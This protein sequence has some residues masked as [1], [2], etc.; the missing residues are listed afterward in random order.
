MSGA[1]TVER[2]TVKR[3]LIAGVAALVGLAALTPPAV[4]DDSVAPVGAHALAS[5]QPRN[6]G[7]RLQD[8]RTWS[9]QTDP[10]ARYLRA[11]VPLQPRIPHDPS[12]QAHP[13]L[14]AKAQVMLMQGDYGNSFF[15]NFRANDGFAHNV[16]NFWQYADYWSPWHGSATARTPQSLYDPATS[17]W[18]TR[19]FEFG[20][21]DIPN[22]AYTNAAHRNG[23]KSIATIYFDPAFRPGLTF[24]EAFDKDPTSRGY[25]IAE[26]LVEMAK[27]FGYDGYFLNEEEGNLQDSRFRPFMSYLTSKGLYTQWYTNT[28]GTW[29]SSKASLLD[30]GR[31]MN[32]VFLNYNWPGTQDRSVEAAKAEGYDPYQSLF[33]G[34]EANQA[35]FNGKHRSA[36]ELPSLYES[37]RNHSP[38]ASVALFTP[39]DMYQ[40]GLADA[41]KPK[42]ADKDVPLFQQDPYQWMVAERERMY[43]SGVTSNPK[44]TGAHPGHSRPEV[45]V[46]DSSSWVGAADFI[47]ARSVIGGRQFH[48]DFNTGHGMRWYSAGDVSAA[49]SWTD[50]DAQSILP[51]W[52]WWIDTEGTRPS[53]DFDYGPSDRRKDVHGA[54]V[55]LLYHQVG[56]WCGGSSLV[57]HGMMSKTTTL[58][59]FKTR[60]AM[61]A[62]TSM[63][64]TFRKSSKDH[65]TMKAALVFADDPGRVVTVD[66]PGSGVKGGWH[67]STLRLGR[68]AGRTLTTLGLQFAP[69]PDY[70]MNVGAI[71]VRDGS[72]VPAAPSEVQLDTVY[73]DGQAIL[74]W[75]AAPFDDVAG[76]VVESMGPDGKIVHLASGYTDLAY[77]KAVPKKTG[78]VTFRVRAVGHDGQM[79]APST[80]SYDYSAQPRHIKVAEAATASKLLTDAVRPGVLDVTWDAKGVRVSTCRVDVH[81]VDIAKDDIDN[82]PYG[83]DVPCAAG[84]ARVPVP[85]REGHPYDLTVTA[86]HGLGLSYRGHTHDSWAAPVTLD[87]IVVE[88]KRSG[89]HMRNLT[90]PDW[91]GLQI[92]WKG[93]DGTSRK[94]TTIR[95]GGSVRG[96]WG[97]A[98]T[99]DCPTAF[100]SFPSSQGTLVMKVTDYAGNTTTQHFA[101]K[102]NDLVRPATA[103]RFT[104]VEPARQRVTVSH[105]IIPVRISVSGDQPVSWRLRGALPA[106]LR[107]TNDMSVNGLTSLAATLSGSPRSAGNHRIVVEVSDLFGNTVTRS[108]VVEAARGSA[109]SSSGGSSGPSASASADSAIR[110]GWDS[111]SSA[112]SGSTRPVRMPLTGC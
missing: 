82:Q 26:K 85:I 108:V 93:T 63:P 22:P 99:T 10:Y 11:E 79:S 109:P 48:T 106:G 28:P 30:H 92:M 72:G 3:A 94:L 13:E 47:P 33:F 83:L 4:A 43:F 110:P 81:L 101:V 51:S 27:Y 90:S 104:V 112:S 102:N 107:W 100:H 95:R 18:R 5:A 97:T 40:R 78:K 53:V 8:I 73:D 62:D 31:I 41:V 19:N 84:G 96:G 88:R 12:T 58:R 24:K 39:S 77:L 71:S 74:S 45:G 89:F 25:I 44:D 59:L 64:I 55:S 34:V 87:D 50:M 69:A 46:A 61:T 66:V 32:S 75:H 91:Y 42:G 23:V 65:G 86:G 70:Q 38:K 20:V 17:D 15:G 6:A 54:P 67:T 7:H 29:S 80:V 35:G 111:S 60:L 57:V 2:N 9:P 52:Q 37:R 76:Y 1:F 56:A 36:T 21:V 68:F 98:P 105:P 103:P 14:D 16:L 49:A